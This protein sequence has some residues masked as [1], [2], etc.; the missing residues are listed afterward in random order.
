MDLCTPTVFV[1]LIISAVVIFIVYSWYESSHKV[2]RV[3]MVEM[4]PKEMN[5]LLAARRDMEVNPA[6]KHPPSGR[7]G[8]HGY[9]SSWFSIHRGGTWA[10]FGLPE[11]VSQGKYGD[12]ILMVSRT[13]FH[14]WSAISAIY[15]AAVEREYLNGTRKT[16]AAIQIETN[17]LKVAVEADAVEKVAAIMADVMELAPHLAAEPTDPPLIGV[18]RLMK[19]PGIRPWTFLGG[20]LYK[21]TLI[22]EMFPEDDGVETSE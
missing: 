10:R 9:R 5:A 14:P 11:M 3:M 8:D 18:E 21:H 1:I 7:Q 6:K 20:N 2:S 22:R 12:H 15:M 16:L 19:G 17:D 4:T 13:E